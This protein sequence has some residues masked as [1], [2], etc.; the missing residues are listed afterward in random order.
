MAVLKHNGHEVEL[1][2]SKYFTKFIEPNI[3]RVKIRRILYI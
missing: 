3:E 1:E 2:L